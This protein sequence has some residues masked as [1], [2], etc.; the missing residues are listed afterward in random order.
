M[1]ILQQN[2]NQ[3][4]S[5]LFP[6]I[7]LPVSMTHFIPREAVGM[8]FRVTGFAWAVVQEF[9]ATTQLSQRPRL[10]VR[11]AVLWVCVCVCVC[12]YICVS[13]VTER[14]LVTTGELAHLFS[15]LFPFVFKH[16]FFAWRVLRLLGILAGKEGSPTTYGWCP[17]LLPLL[18]NILCPP[19]VLAFVR[20]LKCLTRDQQA[21]RH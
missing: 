15:Y 14:V 17:F 3:Y 5:L 1:L 20:L 12:V 10:E 19:L 4:P 13:N 7:M 2:N 8:R 18:S 11:A 16:Y 21:F 9:R 6:L